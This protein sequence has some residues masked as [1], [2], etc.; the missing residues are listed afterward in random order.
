L[1]S[2]ILDLSSGDPAILRPG[3]VTS[4]QIA[5][6]LG[7]VPGFVTVS[8]VRA[9][10][11]LPSHYA[12]HAQVVLVEVS[13]IAPRAEQLQRSGRRVIALLPPDLPEANLSVPSITLPASELELARSLYDTLREIDRR[14]FDVILVVLPHEIGLGL[15][16]ADRLRRA[17]GPRSEPHGD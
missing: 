13:E 1:E 5:E 3:G 12:P 17:A 7:F 11:Q 14:G 2:T 6:V 9:P 10:G 16:I 15:A 4:E 8:A